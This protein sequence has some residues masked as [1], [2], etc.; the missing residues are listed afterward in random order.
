M[1]PSLLPSAVL[2]Y[3]GPG[4]GTRSVLSAVE[5]LRRALRPTLL[6]DTIGY[7][8]ILEGNWTE[9]CKMLVMPGGADLP[10]CR[11]LNGPGNV[12]IRNFVEQGGT[13]LGLCA[14]A[15]YACSRVEFELGTAL[16]V[17]GDRE[18][19]FYPGTAYG[20]IYKGFDYQSEK[21]AVAAPIR[22]RNTL[23]G[24]QWD[25]CKDY[26]NGGPGFLFP[27]PSQC[28]DTSSSLNDG[29]SINRS[30]DSHVGWLSPTDCPPIPGVDILA[31]FPEHNNAAAALVCPIG[32]G[33]AV[34][35]ST[36]PELTSDWLALPP[37][38]G[39]SDAVLTS[40]DAESE[41]YKAHSKSS[42]VYVEQLR[43][44]L[45]AHGLGR[46]AFWI[47]L[48]RSAGLEQYLIEA[49]KGSETP[50]NPAT[51]SGSV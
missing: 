42:E 48:L 40:V 49:P 15:Y 50:I 27:Q 39:R 38:G 41:T 47:T 21:G 11:H 5:S 3:S 19:C 14:G 18:L 31:T 28:T 6:V 26:I 29:L 23:Q 34:L 37:G 36:H 22:F 33:R 43:C 30:I 10:Y 20:S 45:E 44:E 1:P 7:A 24:N 32:L 9:N 35:C 2:V 16:E 12:L 13:Y 25:E 8:D 51:Y 4:A 17:A 46:F